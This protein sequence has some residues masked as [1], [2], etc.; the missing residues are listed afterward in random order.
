MSQKQMAWGAHAS[1][2]LVSASRRNNLFYKHHVWGE[3]ADQ[4]EKSAI[5]RTRSLPQ[6]RDETR[7]LPRTLRVDAR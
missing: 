7:A 6:A 4:T 3:T 5:A 1:R 2:V